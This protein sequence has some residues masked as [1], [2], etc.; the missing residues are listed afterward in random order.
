MRVL[1]LGGY[2][3]IGGPVVRRLLDAGHEVTGIGRDVA[4]ARRRFPEAEWIAA[5][6]AQLSDEARWG[7][8]L[9]QARAEAIVNCAG[10][11][12]DGRRDDLAAVQSTAIRA[13]VAAAPLHGVSRFV[14]ISAPRASLT[15]ATPFMR[16][17]GEADHALAASLLDWTILRPGLVISPEAYGGTALLR[18]LASCPVVQPLVFADR[19]VQTVSVE[20]VATA[21]L[22]VLAGEAAGR[23]VYDLVEDEPRTF[24][25]TVRCVRGWLGVAPARREIAVPLPCVRAA[26]RI[27]DGL[28]WLGWRSPM[29]TTALNEIAAG[30]IGDPAPWRAATGRSLASLPDTLR[31]LPSTVQERW[32][33]RAFLLKPFVIATLALFWCVTGLVALL[34]PDAAAQVLTLRGL[35]EG[36]AHAIAIGGALVDIALGLAILWRPALVRAALGMISVTV[37]YLVGGS[38]LAP[39]LWIDPLGPLVKAVPAMALAVVVLALAEDR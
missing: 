26:A 19:Q 37:L 38:L 34:N 36:P 18:A 2:G 32:F 1:V 6:I 22:A 21:V 13:L 29:R 31:H 9:S 30:V 25:E 15:A 8:V 28:G 33:A 7:P 14:Q 39:D 27:A 12:Q 24:R 17:K 35:G 4:R 20:D 23:T 10:A 5:D 3:L 16:T 11:L